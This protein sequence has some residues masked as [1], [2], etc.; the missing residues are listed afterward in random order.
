MIAKKSDN[1][2][3]IASEAKEL[4]KQI[5]KKRMQMPNLDDLRDRSS[6]KIATN[7]DQEL[8]ASKIDF[9]YAFGQAKLAKETSKHCVFA[10]VGGRAT[11]HYRFVR[12]FYGLADMP[13]VFQ[14]KL[15][16]VL[17]NKFPAWQHGILVITRGKVED[18][19]NELTDLLDILN[20]AGYRI[21]YEKSKLFRKEVEWCGFTINDAGISPKHSRV[22]AIAKITPPKTLKEVR[23]FLGSVQY[24]SRYI[25]NLS[26]K[27]APLRN[28]L[29]KTTS[30]KW[31][32]LENSA[33]ENIKSEIIKIVPLKHYDPSGETILTTDAS[34]SHP[35][36]KRRENIER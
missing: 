34:R 17:H 19:Y 10:I 24:L 21:S 4:N 22:D 15:D 12:G 6:I 20:S 36:A 7:R 13:V 29:K 9:K 3:K 2:I 33:F 28:L 5:I 30:W 25:N 35:L 16:R 11:G 23:S 18:H 8:W 32:E 27:T 31:G 14:E 1:S 26:S